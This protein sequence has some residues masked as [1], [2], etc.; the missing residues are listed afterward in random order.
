MNSYRLK[1]KTKFKCKTNKAVDGDSQGAAARR[2]EVFHRDRS[3]TC[4]VASNLPAAGLFVDSRCTASSYPQPFPV[5]CKLPDSRPRRCFLISRSPSHRHRSSRSGTPPAALP[6]S[7][8][9]AGRSSALL[10]A[11]PSAVPSN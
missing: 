8:P 5:L 6:L 7:L 4:R 2:G 10:T 11:P 1:Q 9:S 3:N